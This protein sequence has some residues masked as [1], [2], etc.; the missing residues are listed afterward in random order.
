MKTKYKVAL[1]I[2]VCYL[3]AWLDRMC[4]SMTIPFMMKD[5]NFSATAAGSIMGAFF[6][7]YS[8]VQMPGG[9]LS[10][11][12][13]PRKVISGALIWWSAFTA[14]TGLVSSLTNILI[15]RFLFGLGEGVFPAP[16]WKT[17]GNWFNKSERATAN[18]VI[19]STV[20]LGPAITPLIM[21]PVIAGFGWRAAFYILGIAGLFCA[22][23]S[24]RYLADTPR[25]HPDIS[26]QELAAY[27]AERQAEAAA[28]GSNLAKASL[29]QLM[30]SPIIWV[31]FVVWLTLTIAMYGYMTWLPAYLMKVRGLSLMSA[32]VAASVPFFFA[33][34]GT[35]I[36]GWLM[37]RFFK[38]NVK[39]LIVIA[40]LLGAFFLYQFF[41]VA[42]NTA[43]QIYQC[44]AAFFLWMA[45]GAFWSLTVLV[46]PEHLMGSGSGFVNTGG[47]FGGFIAP[48]AIG[49]MIDYFGGNYAAGFNV[50]IG[51][52]VLSAVVVTLFVKTNKPVAASPAIAAK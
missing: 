26:Q 36:A 49:V 13:G 4:I 35:G 30:A 14:F 11:K 45:L 46:I 18:S 50:L 39:V 6:L 23:L 22:L 16:V 52:T 37:D 42:D 43:A 47:Q 41:N 17:I 33:A 34:I 44:V 5:L 2:M 25:H 3:V 51:S 24:W 27:E 19:L 9:M 20:A 15:V 7:T 32:G 21:A 10:D 40:E 48:I 29:G 8:L 1:V 31:L 12:I 38:K 28:G